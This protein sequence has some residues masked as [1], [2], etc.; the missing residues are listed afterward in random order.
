MEGKFRTGLDPSSRL[1]AT[2]TAGGA[3]IISDFLSMDPS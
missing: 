3:G 2:G 1:T